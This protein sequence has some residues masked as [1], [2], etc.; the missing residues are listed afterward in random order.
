MLFQGTESIEAPQDTVWAFFMNAPAVAACAPGFQK[1]EV[2][3][4][5]HYKP[6]IAVGIGPVRTTFVLDVT[7]TDLQPPQHLTMKGHGVAAGSAVDLTSELD[8]TAV[9]NTSTKLSW[10]MDTVVSGTIASMGARL[11]ESTAQKLTARF[12]DCLRQKIGQVPA[13]H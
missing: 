6:T 10:S 8:L 12:F 9:S 1:M 7:L 4:P 5:E 13:P 11:L 3:S 2:L